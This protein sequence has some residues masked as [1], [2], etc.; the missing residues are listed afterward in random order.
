[1]GRLELMGFKLSAI[2]P[3]SP[4][5]SLTSDVAIVIF[6]LELSLI[7]SRSGISYCIHYR[8]VFWRSDLD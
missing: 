4:T 2:G 6:G 3:R 7:L 8:I 5:L 1:M